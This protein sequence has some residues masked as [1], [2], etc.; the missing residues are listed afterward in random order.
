MGRAFALAAAILLLT[1]PACAFRHGR[2]GFVFVF[3]AQKPAGT[4]RVPA[5]SPA[6]NGQVVVGQQDRKAGHRYL[7]RVRICHRVHFSGV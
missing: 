6:S 7:K 3:G 5:G 1:A 2:T 4:P